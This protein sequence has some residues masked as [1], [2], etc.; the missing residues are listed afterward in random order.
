[1]LPSAEPRAPAPAP[2][3][4]AAALRAAQAAGLDRLDAQMVLL[5]ALAHPT[6][7]RAWLT[8]HDTDVLTAQQSQVFNALVARRQQGEPVAYIVGRKGF[9]GLDL[10]VDA[11]V[12]VPRP[13]TETLVQWA[14][15]LLAQ[16]DSTSAPSVLD[17]GTGSG[18]VALAIAH[19]RRMAG[20][21]VQVTA[22]D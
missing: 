2:P 13:D 7:D 1:M 12:L 22:V 21:E 14:L 6:Q 10:Q 17:L 15:D 16:A 19:A 5:H 4:V 9:F 8:S 3:T 18:A 11:R 20:A